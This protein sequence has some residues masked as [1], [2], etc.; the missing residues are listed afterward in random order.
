MAKTKLN[1]VNPYVYNLLNNTDQDYFTY[2]MN[3]LS[4]SYY[5]N[6]MNTATEGHFK[7][8]VLSGLISHEMTLAGDLRNDA[9]LVKLE[10]GRSY[11]EVKVR[12]ID[13]TIGKILPD[14]CAPGLSYMERLAIVDMHP[15]ARCTFA[16][17]DAVKP[18]L[19]PAQ[20]IVC[21]YEHGTIGNSNYSGLK[22]EIPAN[23]PKIRKECIIQFNVQSEGKVKDLFG[24]D[25]LSLEDYGQTDTIVP[26]VSDNTAISADNQI[27][28]TQLPFNLE[29]NPLITSIM[30]I[31]RDPTGRRTG[32]TSHE[33][34]DVGMN[35]GKP[36]LAIAD[37]TVFRAGPN[38]RSGAPNITI[39]AMSN[40]NTV[41]STAGYGCAISVK[42]TLK[43][44]AGKDTTFYVV[45]GHVEDMIKKA[46]EKVKKGEVIATCGSRG[47][48]T[49]PHLHMEV[50]M[51]QYSGA[52]E[53]PFYIFGW[54]SQMKDRF[55]N[56]SHRAF[57]KEQYEATVGSVTVSDSDTSD[58]GTSDPGTSDPGTSDPGTSE[59][60][61]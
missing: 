50:R 61:Y 16:K 20:E 47:G 40:G 5:N 30:G 24:G 11:Y 59:N 51:N 19:A 29:D 18:S 25:S 33:G 36:L 17:E 32:P 42:H 2:V 21:W 55:K 14:P 58:P 26:G 41:S 27:P 48:S 15:W 4:D 12:P 3:N 60:P 34:I 1:F 28:N 23:Q 57:Y 37:G 35:L 44:N 10:D 38:G 52:K 7:A 22:F 56:S 13:V 9:R 6:S 8:V 39:P 54:W 46:G 53:D 49:G 43:N 31:R 45:Y